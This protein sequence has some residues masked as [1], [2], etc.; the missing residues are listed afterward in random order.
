MKTM[1]VFKTSRSGWT[2]IAMFPCQEIWHSS[3]SDAR[4]VE[5]YRYNLDSFSEI[6]PLFINIAY[7][8]ATEDEATPVKVA[9]ESKGYDLEVRRR[10]PTKIERERWM[11]AGNN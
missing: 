1:V 10:M 4:T 8:K 2:T 5:S 7:R 3:N 6:S 9:L 11:Q